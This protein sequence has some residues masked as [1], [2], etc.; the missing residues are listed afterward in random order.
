MG[1]IFLLLAGYACVT[2]ALQIICTL[3]MFVLLE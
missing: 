2:R 3:S 1:T